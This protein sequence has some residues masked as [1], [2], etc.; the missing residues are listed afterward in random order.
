MI[1][2]N[3]IHKKERRLTL[4]DTDR[5]VFPFEWGLE[6]VDGNGGGAADPL[7]RLKKTAAR[8]LS[9]SAS[10]FE[11]P[12]LD[13]WEL[14]GEVLEFATP[15]PGSHEFNNRVFCRLFEAAKPRG[16]VVVVPQW[17]ADSESHVALCRILRRLGITALRLCLPYHEMRR[18]PGMKRA[19]YMVSPNI[20]R[21]LHA[22]RQAVMEVRQAA[23]WLRTQGY[24]KVG[25]MGTSVGS[26]VS[27]LAFVHDR[28]IATGVFNHVSAF[29]ADVVWTGLATRFVRWGLEKHIDLDSLRE[30]W[31]PISPYHYIARLKECGRKHLMITAR[32]DLTFLP[33]LSEKVFEFYRRHE[34]PHDRADLPCG[35]YTT[36]H[37]P[38]SYLDGWHICRYLRRHLG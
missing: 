9:D 19:D 11:P 27:Y 20:G 25:V 30:I 22:T 21:T 29:F 16:A 31:A 23:Q 32:Y 17:N 13:D 5:E 3:W 36:A 15:T 18:P 26:C 35:H 24:Q 28:R 12:P 8:A 33:A 34:I 38:F 6:W 1:Y 10:F 37:F 4:L 2:R 14:R 7:S